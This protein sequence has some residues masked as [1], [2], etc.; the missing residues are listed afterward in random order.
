MCVLAGGRG[1]RLGS[2]VDETPKPLLEVA[3]QPFL[4]H[5]LRLLS[6]HGMKRAVIA[7]GYLGHLIEERIGRRAYGIDIVY[8]HDV[9]DQEG[10]LGALRTAT[11]LLPHRFLVLY[12]DTYLRLDY[13]AAVD[14]W[15]KSECV[16][17]MT[18]LRNDGRWGESNATY[19]AGRV[20]AYS[21]RAPEPGMAWIDYGLGGLQ[22]TA[23]D[24]VDQSERDLSV[25]QSHLA[26]QGQLCG[27]EVS[28]RFYEIG[29]P[30][31]LAETERF[32]RHAE[33]G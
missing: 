1:T 3:G 14:Q 32:L 21:K 24:L 25:L 11:A 8:S 28:Q 5:Q 2:L 23:L 12:G 7:V 16:G 10:T 29:T 33:L 26:A 31:A 18:V 6:A 9:H 13:Q 20:T 22:V 17:L 19:S 30:A 4:C 27:F 15:V